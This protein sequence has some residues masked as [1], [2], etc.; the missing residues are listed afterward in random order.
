MPNQLTSRV[1]DTFSPSGDG[2]TG[3]LTSPAFTV[4]SHYIAL[5]VAGGDHPWGAAA[6]T[7]VNLLIGGKVVAT[8][9]G[10]NSGELD[11]T[12]WDVSAYAGRKAQI[13]IV[14]SVT[15]G[16]GHLMVGDIAFSAT[17]AEPKDDQT[18][19][20]LVVNGTVV[21]S[22]TGSDAENLDWASWDLHD[23]IGRQAQIQIVDHDTGGWGHI[24]ADEFTAADAPALSTIQRAHWIDYGPDF[25]AGA[26]Y[27]DTPDGSRI[28]VGWMNNWQYGQTIPTS[29]WRSADSFPRKLGLTT[30]HGTVQ[31]TQQPI[32]LTSLRQSQYSSSALQLDSSTVSIPANAGPEYEAQV[33]LNPH[34]ARQVGLDIRTGPG[35]QRTRIGYDATTGRLFVDRT[36]SGDVGF[37][38]S[39]A[40]LSRSGE[41]APVT[42]T[43]G[44]LALHILVDASSVEVYT[45]DGT[46]VLTT[47]I[48]PDPSSTGL[49]AFAD[50]GRA[51]VAG[52]HVWKLG[53]IWP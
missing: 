43:S 1:L 13:Q 8:A 45:A 44:A 7:A 53:S 27:N 49:D 51:T 48:F 10:T 26:T 37:D 46:R 38:P 6:P 39:F 24:L 52:L 17:K 34:G 42:L 4:S 41:S 21:R 19:V 31:L 3:T 5:Q 29:P 35:G 32:S 12:N 50:G 22:A 20:N 36:A 33:S 15:G 40:P 25:Y 2:G 23:L 11:W 30:V 28:M 16:W 18:S 47:Q 14:D 9:T